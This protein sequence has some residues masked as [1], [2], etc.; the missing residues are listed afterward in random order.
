MQKRKLTSVIKYWTCDSPWS[1]HRARGA[2]LF[3]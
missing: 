3:Q 1:C 2:N